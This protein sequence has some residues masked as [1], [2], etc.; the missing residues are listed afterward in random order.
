VDPPT[1]ALAA[2]SAVVLIRWRINTMWLV[3]GG[4]AAGAAMSLIM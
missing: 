2:V 3:L 4:A 1:I